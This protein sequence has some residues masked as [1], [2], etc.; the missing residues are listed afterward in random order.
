MVLG[1]NSHVCASGN[2]G[3]KT[4]L[5]GCTTL[6]GEQLPGAMAAARRG[7]WRG[8]VRRAALNAGGGVRRRQAVRCRTLAPVEAG[9]ERSGG[10]GA[11]LAGILGPVSRC[12][13]RNDGAWARFIE[14]LVTQK[15]S[16]AG[17]HDRR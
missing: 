2:A 14:P 12:L 10:R 16:L 15:T 3:Y 1:R 5:L 4:G 8:G 11:A 7:S 17:V 6:G 9:Y 13:R